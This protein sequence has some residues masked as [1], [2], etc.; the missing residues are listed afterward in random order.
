MSINEK[1]NEVLCKFCNSN[2]S[3]LAQETLRNAREARKSSKP[4]VVQQKASFPPP[5][6]TYAQA[7]AFPSASQVPPGVQQT[8]P[9]RSFPFQMNQPKTKQPLSAKRA[10]LVFPQLGQQMNIPSNTPIFHF[11]RNSI[12]PLVSPAQFD[13]EWLNSISRVRKQKHRVVHQHFTIRRDAGG[14]CF[15][16]DTKSRW[17]TWVNRQQIK[18]KGEIALNHGDKIE[19]MLSKPNEKSVFQFVILFQQA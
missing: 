2:I 16:E 15:I 11:G 3:D 12:L 1:S 14:N 6:P 17:G 5:T 19:L 8:S 13:V 9:V 7:P 10:L 18:G 4:S